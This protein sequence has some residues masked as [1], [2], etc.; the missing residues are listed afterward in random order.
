[1]GGVVA[2]NTNDDVSLFFF[3]FFLSFQQWF[4]GIT[5]GIRYSH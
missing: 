5:A 2:T 1:M 3:S 4:S